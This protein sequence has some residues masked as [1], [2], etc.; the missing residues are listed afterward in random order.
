[1]KSSI[2]IQPPHEMRALGW[3]FL[4]PRNVQ[5][6]PQC[7]F[8]PLWIPMTKKRWKRVNR[9]RKGGLLLIH[10]F[11]IGA[12]R[13][14]VRRV[15]GWGRRIWKKKKRK[16]RRE[17]TFI[18]LFSRNHTDVARESVNMW[19]IPA[20][21]TAVF[22]RVACVCVHARLCKCVLCNQQFLKWLAAKVTLGLLSPSNRGVSTNVPSLSKRYPPRSPPPVPRCCF[23]LRPPSPLISM[24]LADSVTLSHAR[25]W[26]R[27]QFG[28]SAFNRLTEEPKV[29]LKFYNLTNL[30]FAINETFLNNF[31]KIKKKKIPRQ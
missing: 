18:G 20:R 28:H 23:P 24:P 10:F 31:T 27:N 14:R 12:K 29:A 5:K 30:T 26:S 21:L 15:S 9:R 7:P 17:G 16:G 3:R 4:L 25:T 6:T 1:M 22:H 19:S 11:F 8:A 13:S 2:F